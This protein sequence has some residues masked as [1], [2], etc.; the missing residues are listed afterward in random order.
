MGVFWVNCW[1]SLN[2]EDREACVDQGSIWEEHK[3]EGEVN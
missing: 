1:A 2:K 3:V